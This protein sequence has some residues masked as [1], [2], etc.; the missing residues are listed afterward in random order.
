MIKSGLSLSIALLWFS[1]S[2]NAA[3]VIELFT[4]QGCYSCPPADEH[5]GEIIEA[6]PDVVALEFHVDYWDDL[7]Y[8][9][10]GV[11]KDPFSNPEYTNR[12]IVYNA[13][14]LAGNRGVYTPQMVIN[15][16]AAFLGSDREQVSQ[17]LAALPPAIDLSAAF[18]NN[19]LAVEI[20]EDHAGESIL[21]LAIFDRLQVTEVPRG[22]N[23]GK[24][25]INHHVVRKLIPLGVWTGDKTS[26]SFPL[27]ELTD[28]SLHSP[29]GENSGCAV[30]LQD[31]KLSQIIGAS[32]CAL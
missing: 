8:G 15:G 13:R 21:W 6:R 22:E 20:K 25:M 7:R 29:A 24:K 26:V 9:T 30:L 5:L 3:P 23:H 11:W 17:A 27:A 28:L 31:E 12:Q 2:V 16:N 14:E 18:V 32:Y 1:F 10:A 4:S 19:E